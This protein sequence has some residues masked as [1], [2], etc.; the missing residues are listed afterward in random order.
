MTHDGETGWEWAVG[1]STAVYR[2]LLAVCPR[3]FFVR[4]GALATDA[5]R[6]MCREAGR[7]RGWWGVAV[8]WPR[9]LLDV[10][11]TAVAE[12]AGSGRLVRRA[13]VLALAGLLALSIAV[14]Y[15]RLAVPGG[16]GRLGEEQAGHG[17]AVAQAA[18]TEQAVSLDAGGRLVF[19]AATP[20]GPG[21]NGPA[22]A[23]APGRFLIT[24]PQRRD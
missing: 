7:R 13:S 11:A 9:A 24:I 15:G 21:S 1:F 19:W 18:E 16:A 14:T 12:W 2:G 20:Q 23:N 5:F 22:K 3:S 10:G 4:Y 8:L 6:E 17:Q